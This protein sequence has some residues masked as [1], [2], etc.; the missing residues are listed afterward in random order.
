MNSSLLV[1]LIVIV[2]VVGSTL[3]LMSKACKTV[4]MRGALRCPL[5]TTT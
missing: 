1:S 2:L 4:I 3:S 5:Y